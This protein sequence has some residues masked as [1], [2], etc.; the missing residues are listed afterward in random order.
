MFAAYHWMRRLSSSWFRSWIYFLDGLA[1]EEPL[2]AK[3]VMLSS[4]GTAE[5]VVEAI[6]DASSSLTAL[7]V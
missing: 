2:W 5:V 3:A 7:T 6:Y 1:E 4:M